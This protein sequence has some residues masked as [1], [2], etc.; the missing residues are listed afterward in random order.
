M[1]GERAESAKDTA[2]PDLPV[3]EE[4][5]INPLLL[6]RLHSAVRGPVA[7]SPVASVG[8]R[9]RQEAVGAAGKV[10]HS[11]LPSVVERQDPESHDRFVKLGHAA[12]ELGI[13]PYVLEPTCE[14]Y[15]GVAKG[16]PDGLVRMLELIG[17]ETGER[18][19][20]FWQRQRDNKEDPPK[21]FMVLAYGGAMIVPEFIKRTDIWK[22]LPWYP[23]FDVD[24][25]PKDVTLFRTGE[26]SYVIILG[27]SP[28]PN[29]SPNVAEAPGLQVA[30]QGE[31]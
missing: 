18:L 28:N 8:A 31:R 23:H 14:E 12:K 29:P 6:P 2:L 21:D 13:T 22:A 30:P 24:A 10:H 11:P 16:G 1:S 19:L 17:Q 27:K 4:Q 9:K 3:A 7:G 15:E 25:P 26:Q 20:R 5:G